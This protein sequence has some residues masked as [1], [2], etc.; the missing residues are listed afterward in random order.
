MGWGVFPSLGVFSSLLGVFVPK[1]VCPC[2]VGYFFVLR[3]VSYASLL[4]VFFVHVEG[5]LRLLWHTVA[6]YV[7]IFPV[8]LNCNKVCDGTKRFMFHLS[9]HLMREK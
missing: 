9:F 8:G 5:E 3:C 7:A 1:L 2:L 4:H 6:T